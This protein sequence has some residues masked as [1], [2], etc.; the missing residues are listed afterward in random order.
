M[1]KPEPSSM[2]KSC[3]TDSE[4]LSRPILELH[5]ISSIS[6]E[7]MLHILG[8]RGPHQSP[9]RSKRAKNTIKNNSFA[10]DAFPVEA[11]K[12]VMLQRYV[13]PKSCS[14]LSNRYIHMYSIKTCKNWRCLKNDKI[15]PQ[16]LLS[17]SSRIQSITAGNN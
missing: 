14:G 16:R 1:S 10:L 4:L 12:V 11:F 2:I 17:A 8:P 13:S 15:H 5:P 7:S 6:W 9:K 3:R